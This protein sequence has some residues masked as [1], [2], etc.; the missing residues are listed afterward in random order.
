[1]SKFNLTQTKPKTL[2]TNLAGGQAYRQTPELEIISILLTSFVNDQFYQKSNETLD[3]LKDL[4][5]KIEPKFAAKAAI[6]ARDKFGM[7][8]ITHV[9]AG[10]L[11]SRLAG[12]EWS[13]NFYDRVVVRVDDMTEIMSYYIENKTDKNKP[14]FPNSLKRL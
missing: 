12:Q 11:T 2:T 5:D 4:L 8:S 1:M 14:K 13:K 9:L 7:R 3:R 10:E 6:F